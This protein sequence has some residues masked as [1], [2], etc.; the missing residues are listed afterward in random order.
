[1]VT[2]PIL[3]ESPYI[4]W[5]LHKTEWAALLQPHPV[6]PVC[7]AQSKLHGV[8]VTSVTK[9]LDDPIFPNRPALDQLNLI[10][11]TIFRPAQLDQ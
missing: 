7:G 3:Q 10:E 11:K 5:S 4:T 1:M 6:P 9:T 2:V 8:L